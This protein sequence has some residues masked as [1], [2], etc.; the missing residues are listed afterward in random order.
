L[1]LTTP[2]NAWLRGTDIGLRVSHLFVA[3]SYTS[4]VASTLA[5]PKAVKNGALS[6]SIVV[7]PPIT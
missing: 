1:P 5:G 3:G 6:P 4:F 7:A 2:P